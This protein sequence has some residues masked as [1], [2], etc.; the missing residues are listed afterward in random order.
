MLYLTREIQLKI[1]KKSLNFLSEMLKALE[2]L[3]GTY[4]LLASRR[5][6]EA[7][8]AREDFV[9]YK[10]MKLNYEFNL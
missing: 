10:N 3:T 7:H 9:I 6:Y 2:F 8:L 1:K 4:L 5:N